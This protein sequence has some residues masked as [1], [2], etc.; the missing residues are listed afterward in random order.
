MTSFH[1]SQND[2]I[3]DQFIQFGVGVAS[4]IKYLKDNKNR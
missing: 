1:L 4:S 3:D 2:T